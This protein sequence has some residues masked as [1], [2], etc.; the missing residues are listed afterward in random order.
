MDELTKIIE[1]IAV[2]EAIIEIP[3]GKVHLRHGGGGSGLAAYG[4][5]TGAIRQACRDQLGRENVYSPN[6]SWTGSH[7][8]EKRKRVAM[9]AFP[10]LKSFKDP[11]MDISDAIALS[12]WWKEIGKHA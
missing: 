1:Q 12:I 3:S 5:A 9:K 4:F 6:E 2:N 11:G 8:K 7:S 10:D